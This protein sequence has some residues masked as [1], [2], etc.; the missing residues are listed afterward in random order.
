MGVTFYNLS[1]EELC[2][3]MCGE[4]DDQETIALGQSVEEKKGGDGN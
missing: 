3:L 4:Q 2:D 1:C